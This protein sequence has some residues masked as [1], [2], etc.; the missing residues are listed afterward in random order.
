MAVGTSCF[1]KRNFRELFL[2][3]IALLKIPV[4]RVINIARVRKRF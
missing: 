4:G 2:V 3:F 1:Q